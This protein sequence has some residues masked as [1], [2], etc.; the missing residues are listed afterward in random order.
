M[1]GTSVAS[2]GD[3]WPVVCAQQ[4][5]YGFAGTSSTRV[6]IYIKGAFYPPSQQ[7]PYQKKN[8]RLSVDA[9]VGL[10]G[11]GCGLGFASMG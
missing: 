11:F 5:H 1:I 2:P 7:Q 4:A 10:G 3:C 9:D 6:T 8:S